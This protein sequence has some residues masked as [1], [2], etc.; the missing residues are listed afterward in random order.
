MENLQKNLKTAIFEVMEKMFFILPDVNDGNV[1]DITE[2]ETVYIGISGNPAYVI[3]LEYDK[4]L[5]VNMSSDL[6]GLDTV[7]VEDATIHKCLKETANIIAGNFLLGFKNEENRNVT[8]PSMR[9]RD[10]HGECPLENG[11]DFILSFDGY[12]V[13]VNLEKVNAA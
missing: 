8:L 5:A 6:L 10:V 1:P 3:T 13:R 4:N 7:N 9:K 2:S 11:G 12:G